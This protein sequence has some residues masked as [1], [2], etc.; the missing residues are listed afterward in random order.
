MQTAAWT[1]HYSIEL[2]VPDDV[3][4]CAVPDVDQFSDQTENHEHKDNIQTFAEALRSTFKK[5]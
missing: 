2:F 1:F 5:E 3:T 4:S